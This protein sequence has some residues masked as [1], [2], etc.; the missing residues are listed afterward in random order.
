MGSREDRH[1]PLCRAFHGVDCRDP[2][3]L[4]KKEK[5]LGLLYLVISIAPLCGPWLKT[6]MATM[7]VL[8]SVQTL[9]ACV[10]CLHAAV[11]PPSF[12]FV[13]LLMLQYRT[14][15]CATTTEAVTVVYLMPRERCFLIWG[16]FL[17]SEEVRVASLLPRYQEYASSESTS[18]NGSELRKCGGEM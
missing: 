3:F 12:P 7:G 10:T 18:A 17:G 9:G 2:P 8:R 13:L 6:R 16:C 4:K 5:I 14:M 15:L 1:A 11:A